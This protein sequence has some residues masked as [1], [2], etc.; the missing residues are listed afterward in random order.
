MKLRKYI[1]SRKLLMESFNSLYQ[2]SNYSLVYT[3]VQKRVNR[4][5][6]RLLSLK[7]HACNTGPWLA[8]GNSTCIQ[9]PTLLENFPKMIRVAHQDKN[10]W[11]NNVV[12]T[13]HEL[14]FWELEFWYVPGRGYLHDQSP[15]KI[16]GTKSLRGFPKTSHTCCC[17]FLLGQDC[18]PCDPSWEGENIRK[19]PRGFLQMSPVSFFL[20]IQLCILTT[21]L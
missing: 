9:F 17:I 14:S 2:F 5:G 20:I 12:Y 18:S 4:A 15:V 13:E 1:Q 10:V 16:L 8:S 3:S 11:T 6:L 7:R 19:P 21:L